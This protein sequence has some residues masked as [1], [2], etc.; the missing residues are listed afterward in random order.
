MPVSR[1]QVRGGERRRD[2]H[3]RRALRHRQAAIEPRGGRGRIAGGQRQAP[4]RV[5]RLGRRFPLCDLRPSGGRAARICKRL[6][7][8]SCQL[9]PERGGSRGLPLV[10]EDRGL[11]LVKVGEL[12]R[13]SL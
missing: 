4:E 2:L 6:L 13:F 3:A 5:Q 1:Y 12:R 10:R 8:Q 7:G 11:L 9:G